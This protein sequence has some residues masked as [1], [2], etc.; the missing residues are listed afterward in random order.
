MY[1]KNVRCSS[2]NEI[3]G[4]MVAVT[5]VK[6]C[7]SCILQKPGCYRRKNSDKFEEEKIY[8]NACQEK[9]REFLCLTGISF[10]KKIGGYKC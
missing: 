1:N 7:H 5:Q 10:T 9:Q 2:C 8:C 6:F 4:C 3:V